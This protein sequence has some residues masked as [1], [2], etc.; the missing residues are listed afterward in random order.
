MKTLWISLALATVF[1][2]TLISLIEFG[3]LCDLE[4]VT[5]DGA[6]VSDWET[7]YA[8]NPKRPL[9]DQPTDDLTR[10]LMRRRGVARIELAYTLPH[11]LEIRTNQFAAACFAV[12]QVNG[13]MR[14]LTAEG[15]IIEL[16][17]R[18]DDWQHPILTGVS[19]G[20]LHQRCRDLRVLQVI[21]EL[22]AL[23]AVDTVSY[24]LLREIDFSSPD[25]LE[26]TFDDLAAQVRVSHFNL[27]EELR[28]FRSF[29]Q[30]VIPSQDSGR[31]FDARHEGTIVQYLP[32]IDSTADS[33]AAD[34]A[35]QAVAFPVS[36]PS[37]MQLANSSTAAKT[38]S[39]STSVSTNAASVKTKMT[40]PKKTTTKI[41]SSKMSG[42]K[43]S[44]KKG[45]ASKSRKKTTPAK[46][47]ASSQ[48]KAA[49]A[50]PATTTP[51]PTPMPT[52]NGG[53][54]GR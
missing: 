9:V 24:R 42:K 38:A 18:P 1:G 43:S 49:S 36:E 37:A 44:A 20:A 31:I 12:D 13:T 52:P 33:L 28:S 54:D 5:L 2:L 51:N 16:P 10:D 14:G 4:A 47:V 32:E 53:S 11:Q 41:T 17:D 15:R 45:N 48:A 7:R 30:G 19:L 35:S 27:A 34:S 40:T 3:E 29:Y 22:I 23:H 21:P 25:Y 50:S 8:L 46:Q 26:A 39:L 6:P